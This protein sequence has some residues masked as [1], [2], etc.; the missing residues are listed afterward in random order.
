MLLNGRVLSVRDFPLNT[1]LLKTTVTVVENHILP[2]ADLLQH[3]IDYSNK[4][5]SLPKEFKCDE[6]LC[7]PALN[8]GN[9]GSCWAFA[10]TAS[11]T[12]RINISVQKK[13]LTFSLS[14]TILTSCN[15]FADDSQTMLF[16]KEYVKTLKN[17][18]NVLKKLGCH[19]NTV[20]HTCF[21]LH[22]WGT[23][24]DNCI[25]YNGIAALNQAYD[26]T[27]YGLRSTQYL[28][29]DKIQFGK[30]VENSITCG[31]FYGNAGETINLNNC[32]AR[33]ISLGHIYQK[34]PTTYRNLIYYSIKNAVKDN[35]NLMKDIKVWGPICTSFTVYQ[36]FY[37]FDPLKG[38]YISNQDP[39]TVV[40][41]H[42][43]CISGW[44]EYYDV[45]TKKNIPFWWI[46]NSWGESY[47][48]KGYFRMLRG[49]NHCLIEENVIGMIPNCFP[50]SPKELET[51]ITKLEKKWN[52]E[53]TI[54][55]GYLKLYKEILIEYCLL[56][57]DT[58]DHVFTDKLLEKY[59]LIDYFFF[60][61]KFNTT[62]I[63]DPSN[64][65]SYY[66]QYRFPGLEYVAPYTYKNMKQLR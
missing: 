30:G 54:T 8:Q 15:F 2:N 1:V 5:I 29:D 57:S 60:R 16:T 12:D 14:P 55:P 25:P 10:T 17:L 4:N 23:F 27:N 62:F 66:N 45:D 19:G 36:D 41:G 59:P 33:I 34:S 49:S 37:D 9:C 46:K 44:G 48:I 43:V 40:G 64:G 53:R 42:A 52:F 18:N 63:I 31:S 11:L 32:Y 56:E 6:N 38:V 13:L 61:M 26:R 35:R 22:V 47:G 50:Q 39:N 20:I 21:F 28:A 58:Y 51:V 65:Y 3:T 7:V 24:T